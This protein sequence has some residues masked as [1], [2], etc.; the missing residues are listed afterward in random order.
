[1]HPSRIE[2]PYFTAGMPGTG[3]AIKESPEDFIVEE[4]PLYPPS[5]EGD[6]LFVLV[7]KRGITTFEMI[8]RLAGMVGVQPRDVGYAGL[9]DARSVSRQWVSVEHVSEE[10]MRGV[11]AEQ[12]RVLDMKRNQGKLRIGH[13]AG[14]CF[15]ITVRGAAEGAVGRAAAILARLTA[16]GLPNFYGPQRFGTD[17]R[18]ALIGRALLAERNRRAV[19][20]LFAPT[21]GEAGSAV[22]VARERAWR[23][24]YNSA[25]KMF[26]RSFVPERN[27]AIA[28]RKAGISARGGEGGNR[29]FG[30]V[31][32]QIPEAVPRVLRL[33]A[34]GRRSSTRW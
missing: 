9:K 20:A 4:R 13:L 1:M 34:P 25:L 15:R 18:N 12:F 21:T 3:G 30:A 23:G 28:M 6:H 7:E 32:R 27:V 26:P 17:R 2:L 16:E 33:G 14:N 19:Q 8:R 10:R 31:L 24:E 5:G 11:S 29:R 22:A